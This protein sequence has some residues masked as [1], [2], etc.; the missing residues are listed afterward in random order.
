MLINSLEFDTALYLI[1]KE[2][3][4]NSLYSEVLTNFLT[5]VSGEIF[6][7]APLDKINMIKYAREALYD[8][9]I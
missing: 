4:P 1:K 2:A 5:S 9:D 8:W 6:S 3:L 7:G